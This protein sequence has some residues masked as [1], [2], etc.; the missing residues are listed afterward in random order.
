MTVNLSEIPGAFHLPRPNWDVIRCWLEEHVAE[1][2]RSKAWTEIAV[3]WLGVLDEAL[4][5]RYRLVRSD[6]L[7]W[8][9]PHDDEHTPALLSLAESGLA[10]ITGALGSLA[11]ECWLGPLVVLRF[12]DV[13]TY[14]HYVS[15]FDPAGGLSSSF[16]VCSKEGYVHIALRPVPF[17]TLQRV[18]FHE[19]AHACLSHLS[20]P[21]WLDEGV[22]NLAEEDTVPSW[23]RFTL[24]PEIAED[25]RRYWREQ[26][27][28]DFWWGKGFSLADEVQGH[29]YRLAA[30]L[31]RLLVA[32][33]RRRLPDFIR[34]AHADDAGESAAREFLG[35]GVAALA[36][37]FL[38]TGDWNPVPP[39]AP[40]YCRRGSLYL[41]RAQYDRAMADFNEG[42]RLNPEFPDTYANR[43]LARCQLGHYAAAKTD[44]LRAIELQP[45]GFGAHNA[46]AWMLA[47]C[48]EAAHRHGVQALEHANRACELS[49]FGVWFCLGT[50]AAAHAEVGDFEEARR[51]AQESIRLAPEAELAGCKE[52]LQ[53]YKA[54]RPYREAAHGATHPTAAQAHPSHAKFDA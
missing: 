19:I 2:D 3:Q 40:T 5:N 31:F 49:G 17:N 30:I 6:R 20:L 52:R 18:V 45:D 33:Y 41:S 14:C 43:G 1:P 50:L 8:F 46:L 4:G 9:T 23:A 53:L 47:T 48:P 39:D 24:D 28:N 21:T 34:H 36:A 44:F 51:W 13:D 22:A 42:I 38:G 16:G 11:G 26:G 12:A 54:Q 32:D 10:T 25:T 7:L 29:C 15:P 37:K 27:L 35:V